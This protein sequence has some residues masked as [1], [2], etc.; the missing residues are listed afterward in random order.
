MSG[1]VTLI[2]S[3]GP[4]TELNIVSD[5]EI[6]EKTALGKASGNVHTETSN[7]VELRDVLRRIG[8]DIL[9]GL[10][11]DVLAG[12][13]FTDVVVPLEGLHGVVLL[14]VEGTTDISGIGDDRL[15]SGVLFGANLDRTDNEAGLNGVPGSVMKGDAGD[16]ILPIRDRS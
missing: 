8:E 11:L 3:R 9:T 10:P 16:T 2:G 4:A 6:T 13:P 12:C 15:V 14:G 5:T 1:E 7:H